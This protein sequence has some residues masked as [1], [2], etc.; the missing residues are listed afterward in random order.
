VNFNV[1]QLKLAY[2]TALTL[3][4]SLRDN[5][6]EK[7]RK[8]SMTAAVAASISVSIFKTFLERDEIQCLAPIFTIHAFTA[9]MT[10]LS[11]WPYSNLWEAVQTDLA[12]LRQTLSGLSQRRRSGNEMSEA[13]K[14]LDSALSRL[15]SAGQRSD[16]ADSDVL[17]ASGYDFCRKVLSQDD[18]NSCRLWKLVVTQL[19]KQPHAL[20]NGA[21]ATIESFTVEDLNH[22]YTAFR[23]SCH[24]QTA[25]RLESN[26]HAHDSFAYERF[27]HW[28][29]H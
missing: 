8:I 12:F 3:F 14:A 25:Q 28:I 22:R 21:K 26:L 13:V 18:L 11:L 23:C 5:L 4:S 7:T 1:R 29:L 9:A 15:Q 19:D 27:D 2:L 20:S 17:S 6:S 16:D 10:L 24:A